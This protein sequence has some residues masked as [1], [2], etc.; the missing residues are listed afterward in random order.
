MN[1]LLMV[2]GQGRDLN[3]GG[4]ERIGELKPD[5]GELS[6]KKESPRAAYDPCQNCA[7]KLTGVAGEPCVGCQYKEQV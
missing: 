6:P 5:L 4:L 1:G 7:E 3:D 2:V